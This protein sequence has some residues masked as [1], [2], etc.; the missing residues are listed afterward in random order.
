M[1][2]ATDLLRW[3]GA[4][5][6][7]RHRHARL[8]LQ[9]PLLALA[10]VVVAHGLAGPQVAP[11]NLAT[12]LTWVHYRGLLVLALLAVGNLF[13][14]GCPMILAR[15]GARRVVHARWRW[16]RALRSKW[17]ALVLFAAVLFAYELFDLW[18]L[19]RATA[20]LIVGYF[21]AAV[22]V[23]VL[24]AGASFCKYVCPVGQFNFLA[25]TLSPTTLQVRDRGV[26]RRCETVDCLKGRRE[27]GDGSAASDGRAA[28]EGGPAFAL[29]ASAAREDP[30]LRPSPRTGPEGPPLRE[31]PLT[32][33]AGRI[34]R[35]GCEL[36]LFLPAKVGNLDCTLCMDCV[37]ACPH[38]NIALGVRVPG[39]ELAHEG[40]RSGIG[41]LARRTDLAALVVVFTFGA[42]LNAFAMT[43]PAADLEGWLAESA[44]IRDESLALA[45]VF[46]AGLALV[47]L[48]LLW[49]AAASHRWLTR[50][51]VPLR[52]TAVR[53]TAA[54]V[55]LGLGIWAAHYAFHF[56]TGIL[57][58][59]P[60]AQSAV[61]DGIGRA[62]AGEPL[63][64]WVGLRPGTVFPIQL[65]LL[66][67]GAM[68][69]LATVNHLAAREAGARA[70]L[71]WST[72]V[73]ALAIAAGWVL[74]Q[75]MEMRGV[76]AFG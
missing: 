67:L 14:A 43:A 38:D 68:G 18:S 22:V 16:P 56:L 59:V 66:L 19:P 52:I 74:F 50:S 54:L 6:L 60:V 20:W 42:L 31:P 28:V 26:C 2:G 75:P 49:G 47:P 65:G 72:L 21:A 45:A 69:S 48:A 32:G 44:G 27:T 64:A 36:G 23:D 4:G 40:R 70:A 41:R 7:V 24:F 9:L 62:L 58:I 73:A 33:G 46:A 61:L 57:T 29:G 63:W 71:P 12:V 76:G 30:P 3:R 34:V 35:R 5:A 11:R 51:A 55:P 10:A 1:T 39:A 13:C 8:A 17:P 53:Y 15:D 25:A 37:R